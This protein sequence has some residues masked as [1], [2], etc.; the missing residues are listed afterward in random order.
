MI[1]TNNQTGVVTT[2]FKK[3][4]DS[5]NKKGKEIVTSNKKPCQSK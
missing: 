1:T 2:K 3:G 5:G 4:D